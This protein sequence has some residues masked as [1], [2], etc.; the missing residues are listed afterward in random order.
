MVDCK[1][2]VCAGIDDHGAFDFSVPVIDSETDISTP[3][4]LRCIV[5]PVRHTVELKEWQDP[6]N[7]P[8]QRSEN[9]LQRLNAAL[10]VVEERRVC[11]NRNICPSEVVQAVEKSNSR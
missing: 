11:G 7:L 2:C 10:A 3:V 1:H 5:S 9:F 8:V 6:E 4:K